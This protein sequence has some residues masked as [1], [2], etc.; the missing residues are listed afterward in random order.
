MTIGC[1]PTATAGSV[2]PW[3]R[4]FAR[5]YDPFLLLGERAGMRD[6]RRAVVSRARGRTLEIGAG[7]GLNLPYY[8]ADLPEL[9]LAE[10]SAPMRARLEARRQDARGTPRLIAA[11]AEELPFADGTVDTVVSTFVLCTVADPAAALREIARVLSPTGRVL[12]IEHVRAT[13]KGLAR[14]QDL[15]ERSWRAFA[16]GCHC[17]LPTLEILHS[18]GFETRTLSTSWNAMPPIVRPL[19]AGSATRG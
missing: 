11:G 13:S 7:T 3:E 16:A 15:L 1:D 18:A 17:N 5:L 6:L 2:S 10:P 9:V 12:F 4:A 19:V 14:A 8:P